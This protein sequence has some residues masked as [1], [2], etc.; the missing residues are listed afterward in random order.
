MKPR[1]YP[2]T[3][4]PATGVPN[5]LRRLA[6]WVVWRYEGPADK[7]T[8]VLYQ[9]AALAKHASATDPA[10][11]STY[12]LAVS[13]MAAAAEHPLAQ[14]FDGLG[15]VPT[16]DDPFTFIDLDGCVVDGEVVPEAQ[17][18]MDA[19]GSYWETS[20]SGT[21]MRGVVR[22]SLPTNAGHVGVAPWAGGVPHEKAQIEAYDHGHYFAMTGQGRGEIADRQA[23][24]DAF[25][26]GYLHRAAV[27]AEVDWT[28]VPEDPFPGTDAELLDM[29]RDDP[30]FRTRYDDGFQAGDDHSKVDFRICADLAAVAG[31][32]P[33]RIAQLWPSEAMRATRRAAKY[34]RDAYVRS[35]VERAIGTALRS[36]ARDAHPT[37]FDGVQCRSGEASSDVDGGTKNPTDASL[38]AEPVE[39]ST[40]S[41]RAPVI[42]HSA[43][44]LRKSPRG[45]TDWVIPRIAGR[46][47]TVI[48]AGREKIAGKGT[49]ITYLISRL[50]RGESTIFG[51]APE[52]TT[53]LIFTEE[54]WDSLA[55]KLENFNVKQ[56][57]IVF[58]YE[59]AHLPNW[60]AK[61]D[62]LVA[63]AVERGHGVIHIDNVSRAADATGDD[64]AGTGLA[65]K[66]NALSQAA[67]QHGLTVLLDHH[68]R[69]SGGK[70][71][72]LLRGG[73]AL[74]GAAENIIAI[75]R[76]GDWT[77]RRRKL[78]SR[79]RVKDTMWEL[80]IEL[81]EDGT[82]Y[83]EV[84]GDF[85]LRA[86]AGRDEW[87][88]KDFAAAIG[89]GG[90]A[91]R[92]YL[93]A[94][95]HV[96]RVDAARGG[97]GGGAAATVYRVKDRP[98]LLAFLTD[99]PEPEI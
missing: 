35:T 44:E 67:K 86:L 14:S 24:L 96:E 29:L 72:D 37:D 76:A 42:G 87:T 53:A 17:Q 74:P 75:D 41:E 57:T 33:R 58:Q 6:Q 31:N 12:D 66:V 11:W 43:A 47:W 23:E 50:E 62:W 25:A 64:E 80:A 81:T 83:V 61:V 10:T 54:P 9:P 5:D 65:R 77:S 99:E 45:K 40:D 30:W 95:E 2:S 78:F 4:A 71:E 73:T 28:G 21:G 8:K 26:A 91:A 59:L 13:K 32:D 49:F 69:K 79:G 39:Q 63:T 15:F 16:A 18:I 94:S 7:R 84:R 22:G 92:N 90:T 36:D 97:Q 55:E 19:L 1:N 85:R 82:D 3:L 56:A 88:A 48:I 60:E 46:G 98:A 38:S 93:N 51:P 68:N 34:D 52:P 27:A 20:P 89:Q 70:T